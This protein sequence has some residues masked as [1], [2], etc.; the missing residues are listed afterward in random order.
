MLNRDYNA[1]LEKSVLDLLQYDKK[2]SVET[3]LRVTFE[4]ILRAEQKGF[5]GYS[6]GEEPIHDN[7]RNGYRKS[8]LI[9]GLSSMFRINIPRDRLGLFK[10]VFLE[11]LHDQTDR[12]NDLA[13][14][15]Y[16]KG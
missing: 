16:V 2:A 13:F 12:I 8:S 7:K 6:T 5:L 10:P 3:V 11:V 14:D 4:A 1:F 15:L 9:K